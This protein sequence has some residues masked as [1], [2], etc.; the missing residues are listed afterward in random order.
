MHIFQI[1]KR[2]R[3]IRI[4][5]MP[6]AGLHQHFMLFLLIRIWTDLI[7]SMK[8]LMLLMKHCGR[9][10]KISWNDISRTILIGMPILDGFAMLPMRKISK[11]ETGTVII[12][13]VDFYKVC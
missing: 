8:N 12:R 9:S 3:K 13:I 1:L 7:L 6:Y 5:G 2:V 4:F 10:S 11:P